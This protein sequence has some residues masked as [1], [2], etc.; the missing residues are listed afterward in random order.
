MK[1]V[2]K[3]ETAH[4][5]TVGG[6]PR[7]WS[8]LS[9]A[10]CPH[11]WALRYLVGLFPVTTKNYFNEG[12]A[13][14]GLHE[15]QSEAEIEERYG[16]EALNVGKRL[17]LLRDKGAPLPTPLEVEVEHVLFKGLMTS[18]PDR[19]EDGEPKRIRDFKTAFQFSEHDDAMWNVDPGIVGEMVAGGTDIGVVD[20]VSKRE[21]K[22]G[23]P[24]KEP[25]K[26]VHVRLTPAKLKAL[27][28]MVKDIWTELTG[29]LRDAAE[30]KP[31][32]KAFPRRMNHCVGKYGACEYYN[33]CWG[34]APESLLYKFGAKAPRRWT[35]EGRD[36][37]PLPKGLTLKL[38]EKAAAHVKAQLL[39]G[40]K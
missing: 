5:G 20:I 7:G 26:L 23:Q 34:K 36:D 37:L 24:V 33:R 19:V 12:S 17:K 2:P 8:F 31:L 9:S 22:D 14:H 28:S 4:S 30:G 10:A 25:L 21:G 11:R 39:K 15:G 6:S 29:R 27:E 18:K 32:E 1:I 35:G 3:G 40:D 38:I 13:Y 16:K